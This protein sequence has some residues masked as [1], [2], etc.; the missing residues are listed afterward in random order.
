M[1]DQNQSANDELIN[2]D[3]RL[4][5]LAAEVAKCKVL[6]PRVQLGLDLMREAHESALL[7]SGRQAVIIYGASRSGKTRLLQLYREKFGTGPNGDRR[8]IFL[9]LMGN[10]TVDSVVTDLLRGVGDPLCTKG[11]VASKTERLENL[12]ASLGIE[13][14]QID[15]AQHILENRSDHVVASIA[16]WF[17]S[18]MNDRSDDRPKK[19]SFVLSGTLP[20]KRLLDINDQLRNR[21]YAP[22]EMQLFGT[23]N[24]IDV[25]HMR[26]LLA[27][28]ESQIGIAKGAT[29]SSTEMAIRFRLATN[30]CIGIIV[31]LIERAGK[32]AIRGDRTTIS[33]A[34][35]AD[36]YDL[37]IGADFATFGNPFRCS[38]STTIAATNMT[39]PQSNSAQR[40]MNRRVRGRKKKIKV[41]DVLKLS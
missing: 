13:M 36:A 34:D 39:S 20:A 14:I 27:A 7:R 31:D 8:I 4:Q 24:E 26:A 9:S 30:G 19:L 22:V 15:E 35:I 11:T 18:L 21:F 1:T 23:S 16:D 25:R 33:V 37:L 38:V 2:R 28:I 17:K 12:L 10:A 32:S 3:I 41:G 40:G 29:L 6:H 5:Q